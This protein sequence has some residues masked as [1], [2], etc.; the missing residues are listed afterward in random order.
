[1]QR[2]ISHA[3]S[4]GKQVL[5]PVVSGDSLEFSRYTERTC[6]QKNRYG[7]DEPV[8]TESMSAGQ[9]T[10]V[11]TP[12]VAFDQQ[13]N[14][15]GMGGGYYDRTFAFLADQPRPAS[16]LLVGVAYQFQFTAL[17][18]PQPWDIPLDAVVTETGW[19][20]LSQLRT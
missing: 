13:G 18:E 16:V 20:T 11:L 3:A 7:I 15:V 17:P 6:L 4:S 2:L 9:L 1:M 12:L 10:L 8:N 14:R 5:V 19:Q